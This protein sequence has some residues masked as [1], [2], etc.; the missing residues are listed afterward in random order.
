SGVWVYRASDGTMISS[1]VKADANWHTLVV[2]HYTARGETLFFVDGQLAGKTTERMQ[3][4]HFVIGG[5]SKETSTT[6]AADQADLKDFLLYRSALNA[7]E[8]SA[9][10]KGAL[11]P[12]S[13]E[14]YAPLADAH[15][16]RGAHLENRAQSLSFATVEGAGLKHLDK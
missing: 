8:V 13:L 15:L 2:S 14:I 5:P 4:K 3:P 16:E 7:D 11:L 6:P 10:E 1:E 12:A 9:I